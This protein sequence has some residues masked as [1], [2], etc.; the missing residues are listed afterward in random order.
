MLY[1]EDAATVVLLSDRVETCDLDPCAVG[2]ELESLGFDFTAHVIGFDIRVEVDRAQPKCLADTTGG[3]YMDARDASTLSD[4][5]A[6][7]TGGVVSR[8]APEVAIETSA[9]RI[10]LAPL[11]GT[12][13][14]AIVT[15]AAVNTA[16]E[17]RRNKGVW[18]GPIR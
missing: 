9:V 15:L 11:E 3:A 14:P 2:A 7:A 5:L 16:T 12:D 8:S 4:A 18:R 10:T 1:T 17:E 6:Q 13:R